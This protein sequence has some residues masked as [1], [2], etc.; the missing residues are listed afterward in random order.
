M[1][2]VLFSLGTNIR[3]DKLTRE[4]QSMFLRVFRKFPDYHFLWKFESENTDLTFPPNVM[5][6][7]WMPQNDILAHPKTVVFMTHAGLLSIQEASW[8]GVPVIG[9]P[10]IVD[11]F[12]V[13]FN[14][15]VN[16]RDSSF[17]NLFQNVKRCQE[18]GVGVGLDFKTLTEEKI[19]TA[20][21]Q[22]LEDPSYRQKMKLRSRRFRDQPEKPIKRALWYVEYIIRNPDAL[23]YLSP[24]TNRL[25]YVKSNL[26]DVYLGYLVIL[27]ASVAVLVRLLRLLC[28][29]KSSKKSNKIE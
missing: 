29:K 8:Y 13:G 25:G 23:E 28:V 5:V 16:Q 20:L 27:L 1:G 14:T 17:L 4:V 2:T 15:S 10:F 7:P 24:L 22:V 9:I 3:S 19:E 6:Q 12:K 26:I 11:Q 18:T 21:R